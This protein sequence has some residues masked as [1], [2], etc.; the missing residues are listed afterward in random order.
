MAGVDHPGGDLPGTSR[1]HSAGGGIVGVISQHLHRDLPLFLGVDTQVGFTQQRVGRP[2]V[3]GF[4]LADQ[5]VAIGLDAQHRHVAIGGGDV[6]GEGPSH[7][8]Q[9]Q[10]PL[11]GE[12]LAGFGHGPGHLP[13]RHGGVGVGDHQSRH[14]LGV[15]SRGLAADA[16]GGEVGIG[17]GF[18]F[19]YRQGRVA[20]AVQDHRPLQ[21][22]QH[23]HAV[24][25]GGQA[26]V[27]GAVRG[28]GEGRIGVGR[29]GFHRERAGHPELLAVF[30][31]PIHQ[32]DGVLGV[33]HLVVGQSGGGDPLDG[34][35]VEA[36]RRVHRVFPRQVP[37]G[38]GAGEQPLAGHRH[39]HRGGVDG[40]PAPPPSLGG[41][42][43]DART[44][45]GIEHQVARVGGHQDAPLD[46]RRGGF[47]NV[48]L[49]Q[50]T[51]CVVPDVVD[52]PSGDFVLVPFPTQGPV[53][54]SCAGALKPAQ[55]GK[56]IQP[57]G[58][59]LLLSRGHAT[60]ACL[61]TCPIGV[62]SLL[63]SGHTPLARVP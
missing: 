46:H 9:V 34:L 50:W 59:R 40:D 36:H 26:D 58:T 27:V 55:L 20:V 2:G 38:V 42:G 18:Q 24:G 6:G 39:R 17:P 12:V 28:V 44:A 54:R 3:F 4:E 56:T 33:V 43:G 15:A 7:Y 48:A 1:S 63:R 19:G 13:R 29:F 53:R 61:P 49:G 57:R 52:A 32:D 62:C 51:H 41:V 47:D 37:P 30:A 11:V 21:T 16:V 31:G 45:G 60:G 23:R 25:S 5:Q 35:V 8:H 10:I 22:A 14:E